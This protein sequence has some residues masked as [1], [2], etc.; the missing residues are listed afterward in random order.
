[1]F[2]H[3][4]NETILRSYDIR[5]IYGKTLTEKDAFMLGFFFGITVREKNQGKAL[6][7]YYAFSGTYEKDISSVRLPGKLRLLANLNSSFNVNDD[8]SVSRPPSS[9]KLG[10]SY[11]QVNYFKLMQFSTDFFGH[12]NSFVNSADAGTT[13]EEFSVQYGVLSTISSPHFFKGN[14][15]SNFLNPYCPLVK[16]SSWH[17]CLF[18]LKYYRQCFAG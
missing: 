4:F 6:D 12:L 17:R 18:Y 5:G 2:K 14:S 8:N 16:L 13:N 3:N 15:K 1:M 10:I 9:A 7:E 11:N